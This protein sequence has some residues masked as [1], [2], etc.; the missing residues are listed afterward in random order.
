M[1]N[2]DSIEEK[3]IK[4]LKKEEPVSIS[5]L[6]R[7]LKQDR[8]ILTGYLRSLEDRMKVKRYTVGKSIIYKPVE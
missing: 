6:A 7:K 3:I 4:I 8:K 5:K 2:N 1:P